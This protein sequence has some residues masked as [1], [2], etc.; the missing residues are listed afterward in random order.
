M[1]T[2]NP[3]LAKISKLLALAD[4]ARGASEAEASLAAEHVQRLLQEH[5]LTLA[6]VEAASG[7]TPDAS[8]SREKKVTASRAMYNWQ[9]GLMATIA[10]NN[11]CLHV[12]RKLSVGKKDG[13]RVRRPVHSLV[14]RTLNVQVTLQTYEY[15]YAAMKRLADEA[16]Y[17]PKTF[18]DRMT[19]Y[20]GAVSRLVER[21]VER[22]RQ[23]EAESTAAPRPNGSGRELTL[24][25]VYGSEA[26]QNNDTLNNFPLG[27]TA[28]RRR[29]QADRMA[30]REA[31]EARLVAEGV[32]PTLA[33][34]RSYGYSD[35]LAVQYATKYNRRQA[36]GR[37]GRGYSQRWTQGNDRHHEKINSA[38]YKAGRQAGADIGL[39]QQVGAT[40][41]RQIKGS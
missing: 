37:S 34:Y 10:D 39:D 15:L 24:V 2:T 29:E 5:N 13:R 16:G 6:Q 18:S 9:R 40:T 12:V 7:N 28:T 35:E 21:L 8:S 14:G 11:F 26:D 41:Q 25:D 22:R 19:F 23:A 36:R 17:T 20:D 4:S 38:P 27:T 30:K 31:E 33:F 3:V 32:E 1:T